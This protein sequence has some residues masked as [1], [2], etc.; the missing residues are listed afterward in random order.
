MAKTP[1][2]LPRGPGRDATEPGLVSRDG[3]HPI[4]ERGKQLA[5]HDASKVVE[6][7]GNVKAAGRMSGEPPQTAIGPTR[8]VGYALLPVSAALADMLAS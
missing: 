1:W 7:G 2:L 6:H 4:K 8:N 5:T 3:A